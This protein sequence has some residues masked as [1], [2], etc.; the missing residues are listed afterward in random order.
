MRFDTG[1]VAPFLCQPENACVNCA[2]EIHDSLSEPCLRSRR[3]TDPTVSVV[4]PA[5]NEARNLPWVLDRL[6]AGVHEVILVDGDSTDDTVEVARRHRP[7]IL[8][9]GQ[10]APGKG[11]ALASGFA[12]A[13]CDIIVMI[14]ADGSMDPQEIPAYVGTLLAGADLAK[15][16]RYVAGGGSRDISVLRSFGNKALGTLANVLYKL[17]WSE[18]CYGYA[19]FWRDVLPQILVDDLASADPE[20]VPTWGQR[21][22]GRFRYGHGFEIE[23]ILFCRAAKVGAKVVEVASYEYPRRFG[24]SNLSTFKDG[25][26][27]LGALL[28]E[29]QAPPA[30]IVLPETVLAEVPAAQAA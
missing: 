12:A 25:F 4:I 15:G 26:R 28:H 21:L 11:N 7:D 30:H 3:P 5:R 2:T 17:S 10:T 16:S 14:D 23:T 20:Y 22:P 1:V 8:V 24:E 19:A 18:L 13:S 27:V 29:R 9:V 6:P